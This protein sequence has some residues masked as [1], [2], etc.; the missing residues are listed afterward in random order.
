MTCT[1][2]I[3]GDFNVDCSK[4][5]K[6]DRLSCLR[7]LLAECNMTDCDKLDVNNVGYTYRQEPLQQYTLID[8]M[9]ICD[10]DLQLVNEYRV[11]DSGSNM[12]DHCAISA[13]LVYNGYVCNM[14]GG[15]KNALSSVSLAKVVW[16]PRN[17]QLNQSAA[18]VALLDANIP[19]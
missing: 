16:T 5:V 6:C 19:E 7:I 3:I 9:F 1:F 2:I 13:S 4:I 18:K 14:V 17:I 8:H 11:I 12:S 15:R 10:N